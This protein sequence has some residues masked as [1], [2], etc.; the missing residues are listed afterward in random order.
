MSYYSLDTF[1]FVLIIQFQQSGKTVLSNF[2]AEATDL[3]GSEY[4]PTQGVRILEFESASLES[5]G[6]SSTLDVELWDCSGDTKFDECWPSIMTNV[7]GVL[8]VYNHDQPN[9]A[10][11]LEMWFTTFVAQQG[12]KESQCLVINNCKP[13]TSE[14][15][16]TQL[17]PAVSKLTHVNV[18]LEE[19]AEGA[20]KEFQMFLGQLR[21]ALSAKRD[22]EELSIIQ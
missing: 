15:R 13:S 2:V 20:R 9:H 8:L 6:Q 5:D 18:N 1:F 3:A 12:L 17:S 21:G 16:K 14:R 22:Q 10:T 7:N 19:N 11:D 4:R